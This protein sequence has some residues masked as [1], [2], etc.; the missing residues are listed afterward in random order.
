MALPVAV[1]A[2]WLALAEGVMSL[3]QR[4]RRKKKPEPPK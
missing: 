3:W 4:I 1:Y 2:A